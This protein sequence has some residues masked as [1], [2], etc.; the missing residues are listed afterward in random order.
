MSNQDTLSPE[1]RHLIAD[2]YHQAIGTQ[3]GHNVFIEYQSRSGKKLAIAAARKARELG[4]TPHLEDVSSETLNKRFQGQPESAYE[5]EGTRLLNLIKLCNGFISIRDEADTAQLS[6]TS[7]EL[8][9]YQNAKQGMTKYRV[10]NTNWLVVRAPSQD[11]QSACNMNLDEFDDFFRKAHSFDHETTMAAPAE[12]LAQRLKEGE[13]VHIKQGDET[14]LTFSIK[15]I[16]SKACIGKRNLPDGECFTAPVR[17]SI[18]GTICF[19]PTIYQGE[20]FD[21]IKLQFENGKA[22]VSNAY[23]KDGSLNEER[24]RKLNE[25]LD[26]DK[27][28]RYAGEFALS[29][30]PFITEPTG[31]ILYDEKIQGA[32]HMALGNCLPEGDNGNKSNIHWD[33][34]QIQRPDHGG[35]EVWIDDALIRKNGEFIPDDLKPLNPENLLQASGMSRGQKSER[36]AGL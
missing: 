2:T 10:E 5:T 12:P 11:F 13:K 14:N 20:S 26:T 28:A 30:H 22:I 6:L 21:K 32:L 17:D 35:G 15:N 29:F 18:N 16:G 1:T 36:H 4:A 31:K 7:D 34:V 19:G 25:I 33:M 27:G 23:K 8:K 9:Q 24:T 3:F